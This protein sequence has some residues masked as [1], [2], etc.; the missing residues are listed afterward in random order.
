M[1]HHDREKLVSW[2]EVRADEPEDDFESDE[3]PE[4]L[5]TPAPADD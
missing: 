4:E 1:C 2:E 5:E 3:K